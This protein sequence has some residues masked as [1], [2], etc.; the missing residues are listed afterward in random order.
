MEFENKWKMKGLVEFFLAAKYQGLI[1]QQM[2]EECIK[3]G[4]EIV[5]ISP[6]TLKSADFDCTLPR[7]PRRTYAH[8]VV[9]PATT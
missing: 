3:D 9:I 6:R 5:I 2:I 7:S 1:T 4:Q 8:L